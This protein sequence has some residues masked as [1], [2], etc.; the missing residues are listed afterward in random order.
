M[1]PEVLTA[2]EL[3]VR[4]HDGLV[5]AA[6][7]ALTLSVRE[8]Q[9]L[10]AFLRHQGGIVSREELYGSAWGRPLRSGDRSIDVY[11]HKVRV[12]LEDALPQ[13]RFIHTHVGFGYRFA[14]EPSHAFHIS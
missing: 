9:L 6:G 11:V 13:R 8:F 4:P 10:V 2:A 1:E 14:A 7:R 12:K 3:E 5:L